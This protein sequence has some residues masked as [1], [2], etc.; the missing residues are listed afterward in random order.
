MNNN[1]INRGLNEFSFKIRLNYEGYNIGKVG[2]H[3]YK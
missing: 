3:S 2:I 1:E